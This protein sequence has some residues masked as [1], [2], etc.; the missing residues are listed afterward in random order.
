[1]KRRPRAT[2]SVAPRDIGGLLPEPSPLLL[3]TA[4]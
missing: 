4:A 1:M 3:V 2:L